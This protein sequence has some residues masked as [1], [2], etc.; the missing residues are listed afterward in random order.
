MKV[1]EL[2][3]G[4]CR[5]ESVRT[6]VELL[7]MVQFERH[8]CTSMYCSMIVDMQDLICCGGIQSFLTESQSYMFFTISKGKTKDST[9]ITIAYYQ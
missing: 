6:E 5:F 9:D 8:H 1:K 7:P 2:S 4:R 3:E